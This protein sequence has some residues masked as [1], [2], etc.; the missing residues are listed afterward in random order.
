MKTM[1]EKP[2]DFLTRRESDFMESV[3]CDLAQV[4]WAKPL[5][6]DLKRSGGVT[7]ANKA[8]LFELRFGYP[9][10]AAP[11]T[12]PIARHAVIIFAAFRRAAS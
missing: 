6:D 9:P 11:G 2:F 1:D 3:M 5:R 8:K 7:G 10:C 4:P 12:R